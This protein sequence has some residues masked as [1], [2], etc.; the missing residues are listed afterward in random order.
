MSRN[1]VR[2]SWSG[3]ALVACALVV[4]SA[5]VRPLARQEPPADQMPVFRAATDLVEVDVSVLDGR[6]RPVRDL[7]AADFT[8]LEDGQPRPL[9][10]FTFVDLPDRELSRDAAW[11]SEIPPDVVTN[12]AMAQEG[13]LVV[14]L[15]DR[16]IPVGQP[17][18]TAREVA[19]AAVNEL[20]PGDMAALISTSDLARQNGSG[21]G[22]GPGASGASAAGAGATSATSGLGEAGMMPL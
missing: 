20:G 10:T 21:R 22:A 11:T 4:L 1:A 15:M 7:T 2:R 6:R 13:R 5:G 17:T 14:I 9:E 12:R 3:L 19:T 16:T 8:I 18:N